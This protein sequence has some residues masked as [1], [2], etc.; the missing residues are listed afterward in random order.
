[1]IV[2]WKCLVDPDFYNTNRMMIG[3]TYVRMKDNDRAVEYLTKMRDY[4][5]R[6]EDDKKVQ[7]V[8]SSHCSWLS[9]YYNATL[10]SLLLF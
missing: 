4:P 5:V 6:T 2:T 8:L 1:M 9:S 10:I 3:K 7:R